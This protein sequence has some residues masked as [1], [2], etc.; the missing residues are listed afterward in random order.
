M[1]TMRLGQAGP[2]AGERHEERVARHLRQMQVEQHQVDVDL[3]QQVVGEVRVAGG[4][5][6]VAE[7]AERALERPPE[8]R[9]VV[10]DQ[11]P[12]AHDA[13]ARRTGVK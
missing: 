3:V 12:W 7:R 4:H 11:H 5:D 8:R 1:S 2:A 13:A 6:V 9:L 10:D